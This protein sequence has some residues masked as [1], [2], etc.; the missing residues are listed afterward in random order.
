MPSLSSLEFESNNVILLIHFPYAAASGC[1]SSFFF[2]FSFLHLVLQ[3]AT[4]EVEPFLSLPVQAV[5]QLSRDAGK[6]E[7]VF[8]L[9]KIV[10][11]FY[12]LHYTKYSSYFCEGS[13]YTLLN[14][15]EN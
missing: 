14:L 8:H 15:A 1:I 9:L 11:K 5:L 4:A 12:A 6:R 10:Y 2:F 3:G 13:L 7:A